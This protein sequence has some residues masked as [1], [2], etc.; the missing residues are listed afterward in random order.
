M[1]ETL[2]VC[3]RERVSKQRNDETNELACVVVCPG[4]KCL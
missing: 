3:V 2:C 1:R 4:W